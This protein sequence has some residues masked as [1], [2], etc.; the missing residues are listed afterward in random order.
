M[1]YENVPDDDNVILVNFV[2]NCLVME[3]LGLGE[4][5]GKLTF[6]FFSLHALLETANST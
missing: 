2:D 1:L 4:Q 6:G 3:Y 5:S